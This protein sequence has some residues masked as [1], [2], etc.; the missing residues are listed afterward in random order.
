MRVVR[1]LLDQ[2]PQLLVEQRALF[3]PC[4]FIASLSLAGG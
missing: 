4:R 2:L 3:G 1:L